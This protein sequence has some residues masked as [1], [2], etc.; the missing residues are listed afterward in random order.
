MNGVPTLGGDEL[1]VQ[2]R[3]ARDGNGLRSSTIGGQRVSARAGAPAGSQVSVI[4]DS[5]YLRLIPLTVKCF[6]GN[7]IKQ[8]GRTVREEYSFRGW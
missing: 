3:H 7:A 1:Q 5:V 4:G 8:Q 6:L 2:I